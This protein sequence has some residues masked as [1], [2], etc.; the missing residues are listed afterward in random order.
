MP[1]PKAGTVV[2][3]G[4]IPRTIEEA[5]KGRVE[6]KLDKTNIIHVTVGKKSFED[7]KLVDNLTAVVD[8]IEKAKPSGAKGQ[9]IKSASVNTAMGPG[10][11]LDLKALNAS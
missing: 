2:H 6:F 1:N 4:D 5:R 11:K 7:N 8:A 10:V 9:Y 3:P